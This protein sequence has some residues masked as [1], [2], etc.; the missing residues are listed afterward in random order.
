[1]GLSLILWFT[2]LFFAIILIGIFSIV[3]NYQ[4]RRQYRRRIEETLM[5]AGSFLKGTLN[6]LPNSHNVSNILLS[7]ANQYSVSIY[8]I[9]PDGEYIFPAIPVEEEES[10]RK[11][12]EMVKEKFEGIDSEYVQQAQISFTSD[13][14]AGYVTEVNFGQDMK[15]LYLSSSF[16]QINAITQN[17]IWISIFTA[18]FAIALSFVISGFVSM[19]ITKPVIDVTERAKELARGN[20]DVQFS[21]EYFCT[22]VNELSKAFNYAGSEISKADK[23]QKELIANV[24]HDFKT[25]LTMIK[26]YA[27][28][29]CEISGD[30]P[31]KREKHAK[32]IIDETDRL[33]ALVEDLLD[34]S[35]LQAGIQEAESTVFNLSETVYCV[36]G[37]FEYLIETQ[38]FHLTAEIED[39]L[40]AFSEK[41]RI[42]QVLYNLIGNAFN[43]TG[44]DKRVIV[45]LKKE[46]GFSHFEVIDSGKGI[47][48]EEIETIWERYFR[49]S[50][51][52]K[53]PVKG[54]G[55]GL[56]IVKSALKKLKI[57][58]GVKSEVGKGSCFWVDFPDPPKMA[59]EE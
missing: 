31:S 46:S 32:I 11:I 25:P 45:R 42:E 39:D 36:A 24:S 5:E 14:L 38:G 37:R 44:E 30:D 41:K 53:R 19:A 29:I 55:L 27:A 2:F 34:L 35:K 52:H 16:E 58:F 51:A 9:S 47:K 28:M 3:M 50:E 12:Y 15:Y 43:Y 10:Y 22:E 54:T 57:P 40:Y 17:M 48:P 6:A 21:R 23:M 13:E 1:M 59:E 8:L 20:Y 26:A 49:S 18:L 33:N 7:I 56:S 4:M